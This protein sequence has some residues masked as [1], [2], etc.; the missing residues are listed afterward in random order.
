MLL[1]QPSLARSFQKGS[2]DIR[3]RFRSLTPMDAYRTSPE[4]E[5][6]L[7]P[8]NDRVSNLLLWKGTPPLLLVGTATTVALVCY[9]AYKGAHTG[10]CGIVPACGLWGARSYQVL[11]PHCARHPRKPASKAPQEE[12]QR[13]LG[14]DARRRT[15]EASG[16]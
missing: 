15:E 8:I 1:L 14:T 9:I 5:A 2:L 3:F 11:V 10:M 4:K 7:A 12:K 13:G 6:A 16:H